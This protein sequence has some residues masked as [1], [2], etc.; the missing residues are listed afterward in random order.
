MN[1]NICKYD[2]IFW[3]NKYTGIGKLI[4]EKGIYLECYFKEKKIDG[5]GYIYN[6]R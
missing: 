3:K 5:K 4:N 2:G 1:K 6:N